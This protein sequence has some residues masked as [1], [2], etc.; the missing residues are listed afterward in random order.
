MV[1]VC[2]TTAGCPRTPAASDAT[3]DLPLSDG[4]LVDPTLELGTGQTYFE[5]LAER[6]Q[7]VEL[8]HGPQGGYH[9]FARVRFERL[10]GDVYATFR[11]TPIEGGAPINAFTERMHLA[12]G[13][14]LVREGRGWAS[15]NALLVILSEIH[16]PT[17]VVGRRFRWELSVRPQGTEQSVTTSNDITIVDEE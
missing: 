2:V 11:I 1:M 6:N 15:S 4:A 10:G 7:R 5:T 8:I 9:I 12:E 3:A 13:M 17:E 16:A 14:G